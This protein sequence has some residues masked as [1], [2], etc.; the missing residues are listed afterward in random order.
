VMAPAPILIMKYVVQTPSS[1]NG[2][3]P[4]HSFGAS[5]RLVHPGP[6]AMFRMFVVRRRYTTMLGALGRWRMRHYSNVVSAL[7]YY[8][9]LA[10]RVLAFTVNTSASSDW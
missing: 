10:E 7:R 8:S 5:S 2:P 1:G 9:D 3:P 4:P 6:Q